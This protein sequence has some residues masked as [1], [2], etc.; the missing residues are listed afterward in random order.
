MM[1]E[2]PPF[3]L[4]AVNQC[5]W[6]HMDGGADERILM[7]PKAF[8]TLRYLVE[9]AGRL[10]TH[11]EILDALWL[12]TYV[13]PEVLKSHIRDIREALGDDSKS[14]KFIET[15][16]RR[17]YQFIAPVTDHFSQSNLDVESAEVRLIGRIAELDRLDQSLKLARRGERQVVFVTGEAG[18]GKTSLVDVF[19]KRVGT[20]QSG[21]LIARGQCVEG[22]GGKEPYYPMLEAVGQLCRGDQQGSIS[23]ILAAQ[24]P[25]WLIQFPSM[26]KRNQRDTLQREILGATR[27][28]MLR[29]IGEALETI[30]SEKPLLLV[31]EDLHWADPS[32]VDL[33][34][35]LARRR[36]T[37]KL[38]LIGTYR[39]VDVTLT[40]HPL[41]TVKQD[42]LVHHLCREIPLEPLAETEV[43]EYLASESR[44]FAVPQGL[45]GLI[46]R[47]SEGNP[48]FMVAAV[49]HMCNRGLIALE[50]GRWQ[51]RVPLE[52]IDLEAPE[53]LR[54]MIELQIEQLS[55]EEQ[56]VLEIASVL[57]RFS[58]SVTVG[59]AVANIEPDAIEELLEGLARRH[60]IIRPAGFENY[61]NGTS[62][63]YEFVHV[64][65]RQVLY[66]RIG[67]AR[68]RKLH[69]SVAENAEALH[70]PR[71]ADVAAELAY[72]FEE[73]GDWPR[74]I[75]YLLFAADTAGRRFE[76]RQAAVILEHSL[77]LVN[78]IP[79][80]ERAESE[81]DALQRLATIY[82][83]LYDPRAVETFEVLAARAIHY[84]LVDVELRALLDM[85]MPL[86]NFVSADGFMRA[87]DRV[88]EA[89]LRL[90][91][92]DS[93]VWPAMRTLYLCRRMS[94]GKW[95]QGDLEE[96]RNLIAKVR[97]AGDARLL[98]EVQ[99]GLGY[100]LRNF[101]EYREACQSSVEG[102][103]SFLAEYDDI[104]YLNWISLVFDDLVFTCLLFLGHWGEALQKKTQWIDTIKK[105]GDLQSEIVVGLPR[106]LLQIQAM[107]FAGA[108]QVLESARLV[109]ASIPSV[110]R[111]CQIW[112]GTAEAGLG[113]HERALDYLL[114]CRDD[115]DQHPMMADWYLRMQLQ[116][117]LVDVWLSKGDLAQARVEAGQFLKVSLVTE[118][119]TYRALAFE[120]NARVSIAE[121][122]PVMALEH[123]RKAV[124][125]M[126]GYEVPLAAWR[127]HATAC[128][129]YQRLGDS[130]LANEHRALSSN[131]I[132]KLANS[133]PEEEPLRK[134]FLAAPPI[135]A[136]LGNRWVDPSKDQQRG[137]NEALKAN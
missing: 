81:I 70:V 74:A 117:A 75:K 6:R 107:D 54:Q 93:R 43:A 90:G 15:L 64:L 78:K 4:D 7:T 28:R 61:R 73:G 62:P 77:E 133:L 53:S 35:S 120:T 66:R 40:Q 103:A 129:I 88:F 3:R 106:S 112:S 29:E 2:F 21:I 9:H 39:P 122:D 128:D 134:T 102:Y 45:A 76:P 124:R 69:Q 113:N 20:E 100:F 11:D 99:L 59:A 37:S 110:R 44:G 58:L 115:L 50:N 130:N 94:A 52:K 125:E 131:T 86:A 119:H 96:C 5:L 127:V 71:D 123:I 84:G 109:V 51:M 10:V 95:D 33:I 16:P 34:S 108:Q 18:I 105:N 55:A 36:A 13:Q 132:M 46:Y 87:L 41:K 98:G 116:W 31:L 83:V 22:F 121:G 49:D 135:R 92:G 25:T 63:C 126:E 68:R 85:A 114:S 97:E 72:Q 65:Y 91:A 38:M 17:G 137:Q 67:A 57:R 23:Q 42:L 30:A 60:Q 118:E 111:Y 104:P 8:A 32:T 14:P 26:I 80:G 24:A 27:E 47:H 1:K 136:I 12:S 19:Q 79:E 101:S 48:L 89:Q 56:R 82:S